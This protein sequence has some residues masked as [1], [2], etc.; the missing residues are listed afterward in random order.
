MTRAEVDRKLDEI[1]DFSGV[2]SY[3]DT[4]VKRYSSGMKVR[5]AF[6]VA[7]HL[8]PEILIV[9]EVLSVGDAEFQR[10]C[11]GKME[12]I[13]EEGRTIL[14]V[15]H[16]MPA[17]TRMCN[18]VIMLRGGE[19]MMDGG[20]YEVVGAYLKA[21][22]HGGAE[23]TWPDL[24]DAPGGQVARLRGLSVRNDQGRASEAIDIRKDAFVQIEFDVLEGGHQMFPAFSLWNEEGLAVFAAMDLDQEWR[25]RPRPAGR[26]VCRARIPGNLL[27]EGTYFV[28]TALWEWEPRQ[29]IEYHQKEAITFQVVDTH[30]G[31]SARGDFVGA[32]AGVVR[33]KLEWNTEWSPSGAEPAAVSPVRVAESAGGE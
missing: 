7:A 6:A 1:I 33:P 20:P 21:G 13:G 31:D 32:L 26:Y 15:S 23:A 9:D 16:N 12:A 5:L 4:P 11:I 8:E 30:E 24:E 14:F 25:G 27:A 2:E 29:R 19:M 22:A 17:V 28:N 18:R 3:V 10:K